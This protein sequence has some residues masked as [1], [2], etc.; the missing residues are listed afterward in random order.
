MRNA[1]EPPDEIVI[2][3]VRAGYGGIPSR[4]G[5]A[6]GSLPLGAASPTNPKGEIAPALRASRETFVVPEEE[7]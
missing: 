6:R 5:P 4:G 1:F 3:A 2:A 7:G